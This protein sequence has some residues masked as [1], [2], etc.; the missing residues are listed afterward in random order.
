[1]VLISIASGFLG[2][3]G[4][5]WVLENSI[6]RQY[7]SL[8][9]LALYSGLGSLTFYLGIGF[10]TGIFVGPWVIL[11]WCVGGSI[12]AFLGIKIADKYSTEE[13]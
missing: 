1:M 6:D 11:G 10:L 5:F 7:A 2:G 8:S 13:K 12:G 4:S 9:F 3:L